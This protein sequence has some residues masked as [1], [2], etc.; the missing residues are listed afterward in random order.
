M[1]SSCLL[2]R[3]TRETTFILIKFLILKFQVLL[4]NKVTFLWKNKEFYERQ[5]SDEY[6]AY[7]VYCNWIFPVSHLLVNDYYFDHLKFQNST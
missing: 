4:L 3:R 6:I 5:S 7:I 1:S 2:K